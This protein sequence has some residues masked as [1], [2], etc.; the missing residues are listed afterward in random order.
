MDN[1]PVNDAGNN[2]IDFFGLNDDKS[3][4][5]NDDMFGNEFADLQHEF[6]D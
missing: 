5:H 2:N 3:K 6:E 4:D 1:Q